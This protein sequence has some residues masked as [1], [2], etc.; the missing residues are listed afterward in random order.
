MAVMKTI[1]MLKKV[2]SLPYMSW[3][4]ALLRRYAL[5]YQPMSVTEWKS[6]VICGMAVEMM[7]RSSDTRNMLTKMEARRKPSLR[8]EG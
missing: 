8:P 6:S 7:S 2:Y 5:P 4:A 3:K 1:L